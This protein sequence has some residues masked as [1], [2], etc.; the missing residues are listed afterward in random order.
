MAGQRSRQRWCQRWR[1]VLT[2]QS[3]GSERKS[4]R[5]PVE[6]RPSRYYQRRCASTNPSAEI[7]KHL[8][9][10]PKW[11]QQLLRKAR[12]TAKSRTASCSLILANDT[13][14]QSTDTR[15]ST[16]HED[17]YHVLRYSMEALHSSPRSST[18]ATERQTSSGMSAQSFATIY[19]SSN[20][21]LVHLHTPAEQTESARLPS[22][23]VSEE[24]WRLRVLEQTY[25]YV[26]R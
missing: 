2:R 8:T 6:A 5:G 3:N 7:G 21:S 11:P 10:R 14:W 4:S 23:P 19:I 16:W 1:T 9:A 15:F 26:W 18:S 24:Y 25:Q 17:A 12:S 20:G 22:R 13:C